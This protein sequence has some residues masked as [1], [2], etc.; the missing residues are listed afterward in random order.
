MRGKSVVR[1]LAFNRSSHSASTS[2]TSRAD[3]KR[4]A[5]CFSCSFPIRSHSQA[6]AS[7]TISRI[8][9]GVSSATRFRTARVVLARNV[10]RPLTIWYSTL[11][12]AA[13]KKWLRFAHR[14]SSAG[15]TS[16]RYASWTR[17]VG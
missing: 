5:G 8:G 2:A 15:P 14:A 17:A 4:S 13:A 9:R 16:R 10:G 11:S 1:A 3:W 7:G 12:A 6:G